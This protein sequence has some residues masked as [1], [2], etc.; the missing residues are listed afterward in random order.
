MENIWQ[1]VIPYATEMIATLIVAV[2]GVFGTWLLQKINKNKDL[3]NI[4][5]ASE[6]LIK[7]TQQTVLELQQTLVDDWK[8]QAKDGKLT[9]EQIAELKTKTLEITAKKISTPTLKL[10]ESAKIDIDALIAGSAESY[11]K[12]IKGAT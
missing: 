9:D 1:I 4:S 2:I 6:Q 11:I 8:A 12:Q 3:K 10:L 7:A 5:E